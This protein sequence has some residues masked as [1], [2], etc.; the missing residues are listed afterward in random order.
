MNQQA[1]FHFSLASR[2]CNFFAEKTR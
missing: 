2:P 1:N